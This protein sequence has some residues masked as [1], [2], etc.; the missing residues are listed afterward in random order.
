[1]I[2][3][4]GVPRELQKLLPGVVG[5]GE[6][7]RDGDDGPLLGTL[8]PA[9][10]DVRQGAG[11]DSRLIGQLLQGQTGRA[12]MAPQQLGEGRTLVDRAAPSRRYGHLTHIERP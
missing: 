12:A 10:L 5:Q 7:V 1:M 8:A 2:P 6:R 9:A 11:T 3:Q 4:P